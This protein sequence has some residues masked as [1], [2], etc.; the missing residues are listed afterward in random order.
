[1]DI[2]HLEL[3]W[4]SFSNMKE[5]KPAAAGLLHLAEISGESY[6]TDVMQPVYAPKQVPGIGIYTRM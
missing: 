5:V 2:N 3:V 6:G 4:D 1:M